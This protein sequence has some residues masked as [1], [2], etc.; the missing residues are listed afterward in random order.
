VSIEA[1]PIV[2]PPNP[3]AGPDPSAEPPVTSPERPAMPAGVMISLFSITA[4]GAIAVFLA[5]YAVGFSALQEQ[6]SQHQLY[7][8]FRGLISPSS[9]V[10]PRIGGVIPPGS[11]VAILNAPEAGLRNTMIVEG[12]SS[13]DLLKGPGHLRD[14]PLPGQV[15]QSL[16]LG[17]SVTADGPFRHLTKLVKGDPIKVTTGQGTFTFVVDGERSGGDPLPAVPTG[18]SLL[19]FLVFWLQGLILAGVGSVWAWLRWGRWQTW[20]VAAPILL[21][22]LWGISEEATRLLPNLL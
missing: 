13:S 4:L 5:V 12:T 2:M 22:V 11:P 18:G 3:A 16:V 14:S 7:A 17:K 6:R 15:G 20:L 10:A 9:P 8:S 19:T 1:P 21:A